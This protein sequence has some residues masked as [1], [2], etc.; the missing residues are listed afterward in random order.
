MVRYRY[1][2]RVQDGHFDEVWALCKKLNEINRAAGR[3]EFTFWKPMDGASN[4]LIVESEHPDRATFQTEYDAF[5]ADPDAL[6]TDEKLQGRVVED[7]E[8]SE[9]LE[10]IES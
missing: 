9:L 4:E 8:R 5:H 7:S 1:I 2:F 10:T 6:D 3:S